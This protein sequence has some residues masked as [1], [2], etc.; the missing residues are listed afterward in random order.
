MPRRKLRG[1]HSATTDV[2]PWLRSGEEPNEQFHP[3]CLSHPSSEQT[4]AVL[5]SLHFKKGKK[6]EQEKKEKG[7]RPLLQICHWLVAGV[8]QNWQPESATYVGTYL[9]R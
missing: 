4:C 2:A 8:P 9:S 7:K 1:N 3:I 6:K 5:F